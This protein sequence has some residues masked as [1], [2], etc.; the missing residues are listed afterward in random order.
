MVSNVQRKLLYNSMKPTLERNFQTNP[1]EYLY[2]PLG[3]EICITTQFEPIRLSWDSITLFNQSFMFSFQFPKFVKL[4]QRE[5]W[6][7]D[8]KYAKW[9]GGNIP[10]PTKFSIQHYPWNSHPNRAEI[11]F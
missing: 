7:Q 9:E 10:L 8:V 3:C 11:F 1:E 6:I 4:L 5:Q 2:S